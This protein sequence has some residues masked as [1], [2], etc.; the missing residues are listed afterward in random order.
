ME[1]PVKKG[2]KLKVLIKEDNTLTWHVRNS[3]Q[4]Y[5]LFWSKYITCIPPRNTCLFTADITTRC[6]N[7][8][9]AQTTNRKDFHHL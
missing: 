5:K 8:A 7:V 3:A 9:T 2:K 6:L 4:R 1:C